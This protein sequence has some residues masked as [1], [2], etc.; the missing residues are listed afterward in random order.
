MQISKEQ[1]REQVTKTLLSS[2]A[3]KN[4]DR[5]TMNYLLNQTE[6]LLS[7]HPRGRIL[8]RICSMDELE[9]IKAKD[10]ANL[11]TTVDYGDDDPNNGKIQGPKMYF[12]NLDS[13]EFVKK[14]APSNST[15][16]LQSKL[17]DRVDRVKFI[18]DKR[19]E[20]TQW[21]VYGIAVA[22]LTSE[23]IHGNEGKIVVGTST[24]NNSSNIGTQGGIKE[25]C[26]SPE[27]LLKCPTACAVDI[28]SELES[29]RNEQGDLLTNI[30]ERGSD[31]IKSYVKYLETELTL[32]IDEK[33]FLSQFETLISS[34]RAQDGNIEKF[35]D[36]LEFFTEESGV[37]TKVM[38]CLI[39]SGQVD[40]E[41]PKLQSFMENLDPPTGGGG[42]YDDGSDPV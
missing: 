42:G 38:D 16:K 13:P 37:T 5:Y 3:K 12:F 7:K 24:Y 34:C 19:N 10:I 2:N 32:N 39:V 40:P 14:I 41:N 8:A 4:C 33:D 35:Y 25:T 27:V 21:P 9:S 28:Y 26:M 22:I 15:S 29:L 18:H 11:G 6:I 36:M 1:L 31:M 30:E 17:Q 23:A 20:T